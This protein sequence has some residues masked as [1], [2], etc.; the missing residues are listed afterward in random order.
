MDKVARQLGRLFNLPRSYS[1][2]RA[3]AGAKSAIQLSR[4]GGGKGEGVWSQHNYHSNRGRVAVAQDFA[5]NV[6]T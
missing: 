3:P 4:R 5:G 2:E 6:S 1:S